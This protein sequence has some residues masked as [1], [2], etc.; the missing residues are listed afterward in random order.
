MGM[1]IHLDLEAGIAGNMFLAACLDLGLDPR[2]LREALQ[3]LDLAGWHLDITTERR[4]G[5]RGLHVDFRIPHVHAHRHLAPILAM[6]H[7]SGLP[8]PVQR[9]A[10]TIFTKLAEAEAVVHGVSVDE[11]HFHEVGAMDAILDICGAAFAVWKLDITRVTASPVPT[12]TGVVNGAHGR[13]PIPV[14]AV[15]ELLRAHQARLRPDNVEAELV[16]PTGAA[17]LV[18]LAERYGPADLTRVD[19][20]GHGLGSRELPGRANLLRILAQNDAPAPTA[21]P[22]LLRERVL[23]LSCHVDDMNP[24]WYGPLWEHLAQAGALDVALLPMTMKKGRPGVRIEVVARPDHEE[25]LARIL[26]THTTSLGVRVDA[27]ERFILPRDE[28]ELKTPWGTVR[29]K[30]AGGIWRPEHDDLEQLARRQGWSLPEAWQNLA[31]VLALAVGRQT[32]GEKGATGR[33]P[34]EFKQ[35]DS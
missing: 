9:L 2:E 10:D 18:A 35:Y 28:R 1:H 12:G 3:G 30:V 19:R 7:A 21:H 22:G 32:G 20:I 4:G 6:I 13:L 31:P 26:L 29:V 23:V 16:T 14:P 8:E 17:I 5:L 25:E 15:V 11:V 33:L 34:V 27:M 24:Q